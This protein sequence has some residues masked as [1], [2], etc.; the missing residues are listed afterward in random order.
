MHPS[1]L[2]LETIHQRSQ[3]ACFSLLVSLQ[4]LLLFV[5]HYKND[6]IPYSCYPFRSQISRL[7]MIDNNCKDSS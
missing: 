1:H 3:E 6:Y 7:G 5:P 2:F 4:P